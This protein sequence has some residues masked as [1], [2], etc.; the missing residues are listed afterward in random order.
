MAQ[1]NDLLVVGSSNLLGAV[2]AFEGITAPTF[3]GALAGNASSAT[4]LLNKRSFNISGTA[5]TNVP[6]F[7]GSANVTLYIPPSISNFTNITS[8]KFTGPLTGNADSATLLAIHNSITTTATRSTLR[9]SW[10]GGVA[11]TSYV[12][13]QSW[14]DSGISSD[15]GDLQLGLRPSVYAT[16]GTELCMMID[17]DYYSMGKK[18]AHGAN[19]SFSAWTAGTTAGPKINL[20][21]GGATLTSAAVPSASTSAS[22]IVTTG[23]QSFVGTKTF[24]SQI[25]STF[26]GG[27]GSFY[28][29]IAA[30]AWAYMRLQS[31][32]GFWDVAVNS[33]D[34]SG[35]FQLRPNGLGSKRFYVTTDGNATVEGTYLG[36]G[37]N[38]VQLTYVAATESLD[39]IFA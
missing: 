18:V 19:S 11:M 13:G 37:A 31:G 5:S 25:I 36:I 38:K 26:T 24:T 27:G 17:G 39:F 3:T 2:N 20:S 29:N 22:G 16:G 34:T 7:D 35:A 23:S 9:S 15:C 8:A 6:E 4:K 1:L 33:G 32:T 28:S 30:N 10:T 21:L 14:I 12:W